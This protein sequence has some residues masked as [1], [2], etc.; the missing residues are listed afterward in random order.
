MDRL[1][2][3]LSR[4]GLWSRKEARKIIRAG[5]VAVDGSFI[6]NPGEQIGSDVEIDVDGARINHE[7]KVYL[8]M[9]KPSGLISSTEDPREETVLELLPPQYKKVGLFPVG[10]LDKD[11]EGLLL[12]TNDGPLAHHLLSPRHHVEKVYF[13]KVRGELSQEDVLSFSKG[14]LL[15]DGTL[16]REARLEILEPSDT[17]LVT[18]REGK[19]HQL[20]RMMA[21]RSKPVLYLKRICMGSL[22]LDPTLKP[23]QWRILTKKETA[24]LQSRMV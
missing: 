16:C 17:A 18:L 2:K 19:Y 20:K 12:L 7:S 13:V 10:R 3:V 22:K 1:D 9:N 5:R 14:I 24:Q 15:N 21:A 6:K 4:T 8:M 23:G 11:T